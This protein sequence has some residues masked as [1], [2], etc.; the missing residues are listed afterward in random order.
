ML[1]NAAA[2]SASAQAR[3]YKLFDAGGLFLFVAPS[4]LKSWRLKY[5]FAGKEKLLTIG[6]FP[7][8][9][10][11]EARARR[12]ATKE[13]LRVGTDPGTAAAQAGNGGNTFEA[14]ARSWH[15]HRS[16]GWSPTHAAD[17]LAS[18]ERDIFPR[19]GALP[20]GAIEAP[21]LLAALRMVE[22]RGR[23]ETAR[24]L[25]QRLSA[26]FGYAE[27]E[28]HLG[29][30]HD[31]ARN[32]GRAMRAARPP[33]PQPA[34]TSIED[35]RALLAACER[36][37]TRRAVVLASRFLALT[38]VRLD[39]VRG[40]RWGEIEG[41][42]GPEPNW[43]V[44]PARMK[45]KRAKKDDPASEHLVPLSAAAV[46]VLREALSI[47][48]TSYEAEKMDNG[49]VFHSQRQTLP[50][51]EGAIR[52]LYAR[53]GFAGRHVPHG[54]RA[55]FS[56]IM[57]ELLGDAW[58]GTIDRAL[59][60]SPKDKVEGAYNRAQQL[61]RRREVFNRWGELLAG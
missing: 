36:Q 3:A 57:N 45:L 5:R 30:E 19:L 51:G 54:W 12:E 39:A 14:V 24:R 4:G 28:G 42:D 43:R 31:P 55:S 21:L 60:H 10:L 37:A 49:L 34:L 9:S 2:K 8:I 32:L 33:R 41:L 20:I 35:C 13:L 48:S 15:A 58:S 50:L 18:L 23:I 1:T 26:I 52:T 17:V 16:D 29:Q 6:R 25:R 56:T 22:G 27:A 46:A 38:A 53:A 7:E 40:M 59:A 44:P 47:L 11:A 61:D